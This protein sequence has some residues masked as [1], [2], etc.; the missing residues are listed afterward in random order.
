ML[1]SRQ[2]HIRISRYLMGTVRQVDDRH[3][4]CILAMREPRWCLPLRVAVP[5]CEPRA[6]AV[7]TLGVFFLGDQIVAE[8]EGD[9]QT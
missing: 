6:A 5:S 2:C 1:L 9:R 7:C 4:G 8:R 3:D